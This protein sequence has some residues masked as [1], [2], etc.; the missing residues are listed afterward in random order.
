MEEKE[1]E[2]DDEDEGEE[3]EEDDEDDDG[4]DISMGATK[5]N[6]VQGVETSSINLS[7][8][9][10]THGL[11]VN[12]SHM[13]QSKDPAATPLRRPAKLFATTNSRSEDCVPAREAA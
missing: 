7:S 4:D 11:V 6:D 12:T 2:D 9:L 10:S 5:L 3:E 13:K 8:P 1:E